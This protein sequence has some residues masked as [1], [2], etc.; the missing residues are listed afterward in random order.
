[1]KRHQLISTLA[2]SGLLAFCGG[3]ARADVVKCVDQEGH[4]TLTDQG[5]AD[6]EV[7]E[8][9]SE[10]VAPANDEAVTPRGAVAHD[11]QVARLAPAAAMRA[12]R[13]KSWEATRVQ[14]PRGPSPDALTMKAARMTMQ[15]LDEQAHQAKL[16]ASR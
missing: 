14:L 6:G 10:H 9:P 1:M 12:M 5:C 3:A 2:L 7:A 4:A 15:M 16:V 11:A 8:A 13:A